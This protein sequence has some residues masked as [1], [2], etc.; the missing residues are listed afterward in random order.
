[1]TSR[2]KPGGWKSQEPDEQGDGPLLQRRFVIVRVV[3]VLI[4][5]ALAIQLLN[6]QVFQGHKYRLLAVHNLIKVIPTLPARGLIFDRYGRPLAENVPTFSVTLIPS[7]IPKG[8]ENAVYS[9]LQTDLG[10]PASDIQQKV[11]N[12]LRSSP[13]D[14]P[15]TIKSGITD[16]TIAMKL[17]ELRSTIPA[18]SV[19]ADP[20]RYYPNGSLMAHI[21]G[22]VGKING[23][24]YKTLQ[25]KGYQI[26]D[27]IGKE[28]LEA[29][30]ETQLRGKPGQQTVEI[31]AAGNELRPLGSQPAQPGDNLTLT[32]DSTLQDAIAKIMAQSLQ[33]YQSPSGVAIM[34]D[35]HT[36]AIL[37]DVS[38]PTFD[39]N[40]FSSPIPD[41]TWQQLLNDPGRPLVDH[42]IA[43]HYPPGSTFKMITGLAALQQGVATPSTTIVTN[44]KLVVNGYTFPDWQNNGTLDF[45]KG[46]AMS[47]DV[48]FYCLSGG[49]PDLP[50]GIPSNKALGPNTIAKY[51]RMLGLGSPTG[52]DLPGEVG[53]I[54]PDT[55]WKL[56]TQHQQWLLGDT[57]YFG[58]GQGYV[59]ATPMQMIRVVAAIANGGQLL[60]PHLVQSI[61]DASGNLVSEA[62]PAVQGQLAVSQ[63][64]LATMRQAMRL[65]VVAGSAPAANVPGIAIAGKSGTAEYGQRL[66][67]TSGEEANGSYNESG[68]YVSFA[69]Y[70]NPQVALLV[71]DKKG[72]GAITAA[73]TSTKIWEY[74]F[75]QYL[76]SHPGASNGTAPTPTSSPST[77]AAASPTP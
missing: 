51:A 38:L 20:S 73:P 16:P 44:G 59:A 18:L 74:Y 37:A 39:N 29:S 30:Y 43:D 49:C 56:R 19:K 1:M 47:S 58:I 54:V 4:F 25:S 50:G 3:V 42:T 69:P 71:F 11:T 6:V 36:G 10:M 48:Y 62:G 22:Y 9:A 14:Q 75:N 24:E 28:G 13:P 2:P 68:W 72:G 45:L 33:Q 52:I 15:V 5:I 8:K 63:Q 61:R 40:L 12:A 23:A 21:L 7:A 70:D 26:N 77:G 67:V 57:Y 66:T 65:E 31:D 35:V 34:M 53:G 32:V 55:Q 64:N 27:Q 76:P 17:A 60:R 41:N 46:F